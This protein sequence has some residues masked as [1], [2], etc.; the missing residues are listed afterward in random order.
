MAILARLLALTA[1]LLCLL[2]H[3]SSAPVCRALLVGC[4]HF[5]TQQDTAPASANNVARVAEALQSGSLPFERVTTSTG[6]IADADALSALV[7]EA[8]RGAADGDVSYFYISTHGLWHQGQEAGD[9][10]LVLSDGQTEGGVTASRLREMFDRVPGVKVLLLDACHAGAVIGKGTADTIANV[11]SAP[12]YKIICSSGGAEESWFWAGGTDEDGLDTGAGYFSDMLATGLGRAGGFAADDDGDGVITLDELK[13]FLR[14]HHGA[15]TVQTYPEEDDFALMTYAPSSVTGRAE[16]AIANVTMEDG[17]LDPADPVASF[18]F[19]VLRDTRVAYQLVLQEQGRWDFANATVLWDNAEQSSLLGNPEG[20]LSPGYKERTI[21]LTPAQR[22]DSYGYA[23]LQIIT[24]TRGKVAVASSHVL[25]VPPPSG[26]ME[27]SVRSSEAFAPASG[28]EMS[29]IVR[30]ELPCELSVTIETPEGEA[31]RRLASRQASRPE[32]LI[33]AGS[34]F[35]WNGRLAS[36]EAAESGVYVA[37]VRAW[38]GSGSFEAW[39][40]P[41]ELLEPSG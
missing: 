13:R 26:S 28:E 15:S 18:G 40:E 6:S 41:F 17:A 24:V 8:F 19:T 5:V 1:M 12:E 9:M 34:T 21:R 23:L 35:V 30:H 39:S 29:I 4:D 14:L 31:V 36:G 22:S 37:H 20:M 11:F 7:E 33:P 2:P 10:T 16:T 38:I 3:A 27:L 25:C 32:Q